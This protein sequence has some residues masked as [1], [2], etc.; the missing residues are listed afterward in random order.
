MVEDEALLA[1]HVDLTMPDV[2]RLHGDGSQMPFARRIVESLSEEGLMLF[3]RAVGVDDQMT[4][5]THHR[6]M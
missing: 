1:T 5:G 6:G 4:V 2:A 3:E